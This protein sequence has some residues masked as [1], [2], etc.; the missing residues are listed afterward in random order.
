M[1]MLLVREVICG[2]LIGGM[3]IIPKHS[4]DLVNIQISM[5]LSDE[6]AHGS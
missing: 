5:E 4:R 2:L 3:N 6:A 1:F